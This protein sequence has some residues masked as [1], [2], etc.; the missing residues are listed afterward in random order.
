MLFDNSFEGSFLHSLD[1][2]SQKLSLL[3]SDLSDTGI[4][5][6]FSDT[7]LDELH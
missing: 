3:T 1:L 5:G 6:Q 4:M 2:L 7:S